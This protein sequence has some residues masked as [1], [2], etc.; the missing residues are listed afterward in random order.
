MKLGVNV[1][2]NEE[3]SGTFCEWFVCLSDVIMAPSAV[4]TRVTDK[5]S[6]CSNQHVRYIT[7]S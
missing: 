5:G 6:K 1:Q 4:Q 3:E 7:L 2:M